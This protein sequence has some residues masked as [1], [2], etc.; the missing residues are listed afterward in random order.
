MSFFIVLENKTQTSHSRSVKEWKAGAITKQQDTKSTW[1]KL[2]EGIPL[3][4]KSSAGFFSYLVLVPDSLQD[5]AHR[6]TP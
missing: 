4:K 5:Q 1:N 6:E 3:R 2:R